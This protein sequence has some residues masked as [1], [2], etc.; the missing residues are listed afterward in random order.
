MQIRCRVESQSGP[1]LYVH[2]RAAVGCLA[3]L[4]WSLLT[5]EIAIDVIAFAFSGMEFEH[6][7]GEGP[8][9]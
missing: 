3:D 9:R 1:A 8:L 7:A 6:L 4:G 2:F 5:S